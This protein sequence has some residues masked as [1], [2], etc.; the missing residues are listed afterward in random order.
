MCDRHLN[1][2]AVCTPSPLLRPAGK[3]VQ[4]TAV[5]PR[6]RNNPQ[7]IAVFIFA[8][9]GLFPGHIGI[10]RGPLSENGHSLH[11]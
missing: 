8:L 1:P 2:L 7:D 4:F 5:S 11:F 3:D 10:N 9:S 6:I